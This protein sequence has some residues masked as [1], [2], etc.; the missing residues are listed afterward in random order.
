MIW[1]L[2]R[3]DGGVMKVNIIQKT[4]QILVNIGSGV[5]KGFHWENDNEKLHL[6]GGQYQ[7]WLSFVCELR[8]V[9]SK[10]K[11]YSVQN[12]NYCGVKL[13]N[14][15]SRWRKRVNVKKWIK[16]EVIFKI[17]PKAPRRK[18]SKIIGVRLEQEKVAYTM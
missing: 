3:H 9:K 14:F 8:G 15:G 7:R 2:Q 18:Q 4:N 6:K 5:E 13:K 17:L 1:E 10:T 16:K 12:R 11:F